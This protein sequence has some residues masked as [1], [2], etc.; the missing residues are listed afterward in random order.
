MFTKVKNILNRPIREKS[1]ALV[2]FRTLFTYVP[3]LH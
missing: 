3:C 2:A 1:K